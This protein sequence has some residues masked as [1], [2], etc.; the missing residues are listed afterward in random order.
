MSLTLLQHLLL[1][2]ISKVI[3]G[4]PIIR[5]ASNTYITKFSIETPS[6][7]QPVSY[8]I[9]SKRG[10]RDQFKNMIDICHAAGVQVIAD[11]VINHMAGA[12][13]GESLFDDV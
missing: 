13:S 12:D 4:L 5:W 1:K 2:S 6:F 9:V 10:N 3:S 7:W 11:S 8:N